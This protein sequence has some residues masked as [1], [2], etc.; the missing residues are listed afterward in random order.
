[1]QKVYEFL[2]WNN[3]SN[4]CTF[5]HQR[6]H[7]RKID[8]KILTPE[9]QVES[10]KECQR[11]LD[12]NEFEKGNHILL[13]GGE[14]FDI[15]SQITKYALIDLLKFIKDKMCLNDIDLLYINTNLLYEDTE[16]LNWFLTLYQANNLL[17]RIK[18]TTSYDIIGRFTSKERELL[19]Y[20]NLKYIT[21]T[22]SNIHVV[23]NTVLTNEACK[24]ICEDKFGADYLLEYLKDQNKDNFTI[25]DWI[26]YFKVDINTIPYIKLDY[27]EAPQMPKKAVVFETL[28]HIDRIIPGYLKSYADNIALKQEKAL[29]EYNKNRKE[30]EYCSSRLAECGHSVNFQLSFTDSNECFPCAIQKLVK[31]K[32]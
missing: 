31:H 7:E 8:D 30:F 5:C 1:M 20:R 18:F 22:Y 32:L 4:N 15:K 25:K 9:E 19:F 17:E 12:S 27:N 14:I 24:R 29:Y 28:L 21:D 11:F 23:V 3:C 6:N 13:V 2:L 16:L 10:L 26:A